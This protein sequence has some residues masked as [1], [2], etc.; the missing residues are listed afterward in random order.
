MRFINYAIIAL[1]GFSLF[2]TLLPISTLNGYS[3]PNSES[4]RGTN[5][6]P[7]FRNI[8]EVNDGRFT[9]SQTTHEG[10][11]DPVSMLQSGY[12]TTDLTRART[13]TG[14]NT[15]RNITIDDTNGW[16]INSTEIEVTNL[17]R[18]YAV[19]GTF[20][21]GTDPWITYSVNGGQNTQ[22]ESYN[23]SGEYLV[24]R[25][26]GRN[27]SQ[28]GYY[29]HSGG[30]WACWRQVMTNTP[31]ALSF[32]LDFDFRYVTGPLDPQG[33][34]GFSGD[35]G[36]VWLLQSNGGFVEGWYWP[37]EDGEVVTSRNTWYSVN[38]DYTLSSP[39]SQLILTIG[40]YFAS[41]VHVFNQDYDG[42][43]ANDGVENAQNVTVYIDNIEF[44]STTPLNFGDVGLT[45]HAGSFSSPISGTGTGTA[46]ITNPDLWTSDSLG[47]QITANSNVVFSYSITSQF[48]RYLNSS[49]TTDLSK[50]GVAYSVTSESSSSLR[51]YTYVTQPS[52][53]F[54]ATIDIG[55]P[56]DWENAT[57]WDPLMYNI[58]NLCSTETGQIHVPTSELSR[59]GWWEINL[60]SPNYAKNVSVQTYNQGNGLWL[61]NSLFR[62]SNNT[63]VQVE[64]GTSGVTP[65]E[66]APVNI[67]WVL[68]NE[69][70]WAT[71]SIIT[72][73][74]GAVTSS[75][76]TFG[77]TN[78]TAGEWSIDILWANGT[79]IAFR[80]VSFDLYHSA[81]IAATY[82]VI[83][84]NYGLTISNLITLKDADT[85][86]YLLDDSVTIEANWS[87]S[88]VAFAQ[89]YAKKWWEADFET[90][91]ISE[92]RFV[93][94][95]SAS[96]PYFDDVS[97]QFIVIAT[98]QTT[99]EILNAG[100]IP[101]E[102]GL[103][104]VFT[105]QMEY[106]L[107][108]GT[109]VSGANIY[110]SHSGPGGGLTWMNFIDNNNGLYSVDIVCDV[111][112]SYPITI[113]LNKTYYHSASDSFTLI[114]TRTGTVLELINGT[115]DVVRYG[116]NY[117]LVMQYRNSTGDGLETASFNVVSVTSM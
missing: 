47:C 81:S 45:F 8:E 80:S 91:L 10:V 97:T 70:Q 94:L 6:S 86:E 49:W 88:V 38:E 31:A 5:D 107:L 100:A 1:I 103:N 44:V 57:I 98:Q 99:F 18:L 7:E 27:V 79:E 73:L 19:N 33:D 74:G 64:I 116:D 93:V 46:K 102:R 24:C 37:M 51:F 69:E 114:I 106:E 4:P 92:G 82:P 40:L 54:G 28:F 11:I 14:T 105:V 52:G 115:S 36:V 25:N 39:D 60:N 113:T 48:Q 35:V 62:P 95:V 110:I 32:T 59:S 50:N 65:I 71:D 29:A 58:T 96:R 12:Q 76:W 3:E 61:E 17:R 41:D 23:S 30:T 101:V 85:N 67:T 16:A 13:D 21:D 72:M 66:G 83:E 2:A 87:S 89:N 104:E 15:A 53:Y 55:Y 34:D 77:S 90:S 111:S 108:N 43:G 84:T 22:I 75:T 68:P 109:G 20:E 117:R 56:V 9:I 42:N 63:R 26:V 78:T 112:D